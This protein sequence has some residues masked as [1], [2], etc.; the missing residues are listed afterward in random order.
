MLDRRGG[1]GQRVRRYECTVMIAQLKMTPVSPPAQQPAHKGK[2][3]IMPNQL[4]LKL[5]PRQCGRYNAEVAPPQ[6]VWQV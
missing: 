5:P 6:A 2:I 1:K 3:K 4:M